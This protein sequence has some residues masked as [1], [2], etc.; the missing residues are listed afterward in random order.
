MF[1][2]EMEGIDANSFIMSI[3]CCRGRKM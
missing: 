3:D 2:M 1:A